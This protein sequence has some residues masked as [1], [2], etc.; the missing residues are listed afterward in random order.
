MLE[1]IN[2]PDREPIFAYYD[3]KEH[4]GS[5][6]L[7]GECYEEY[8]DRMQTEYSSPVQKYIIDYYSSALS[9][10]VLFKEVVQSP[11]ENRVLSLFPQEVVERANEQFL[12]S[13][14][15]QNEYF[16]EDWDFK[17]PVSTSK[18]LEL[19]K[20]ANMVKYGYALLRKSMIDKSK[21]VFEENI[22]RSKRFSLKVLNR[23]LGFK[24]EEKG[25]KWE[26]R[27]SPEEAIN[28][29]ISTHL[30]LFTIVHDYIAHEEGLTYKEW[31]F[32]V[33]DSLKDIV[34]NM[35]VPKAV[36]NNM[37]RLLE[38]DLVKN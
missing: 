26:P 34:F 14:D 18:K 30:T 2:D 37:R 17:I 3:E 25:L 8:V 35:G 33:E 12:N 20:S 21:R 32:Y 38:Q 23:L 16:F 5:E 19:I 10:S 31:T 29:V 28:P 13:P 6:I 11:E 22:G 4:L 7:E 36:M 15:N 24:N 9:A 1:Y 27:Y